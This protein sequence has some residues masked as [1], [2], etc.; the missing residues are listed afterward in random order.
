[1][2]I[3]AISSQIGLDYRIAIKALIYMDFLISSQTG[4]LAS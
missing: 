4:A 3:A 2:G 1:M